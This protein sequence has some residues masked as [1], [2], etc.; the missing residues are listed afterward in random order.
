M[1]FLSLPVTLEYVE[2]VFAN[3]RRFI[4]GDNVDD[5][6]DL[7]VLFVDCIEVRIHAS[8]DKRQLAIVVL[9]H[10]STLYQDSLHRRSCRCSVEELVS[11][12]VD[13]L[14]NSAEKLCADKYTVRH[15]QGVAGAR[16]G[17]AVTAQA[18]V[19][20]IVDD[21]AASVSPERGDAS[22]RFAPP[23]VITPSISRLLSAAKVINRDIDE[24]QLGL[25]LVKQLV[26]SKGLDVIDKL[27]ENY[28]LEVQ[29][30]T[31][32]L[33]QEAVSRPGADPC[34]HVR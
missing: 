12:A 20:L 29:W 33:Q 17:L 4:R 8:K 10:R 16:F 25:F 24:P 14:K 31:E 26:R 30:L 1:V 21:E 22:L 32:L 6:E 18:L 28:G 13:E 23:S 7:C 2:I 3:A 15:L 34:R 19:N 5:M 9:M 27:Q 11:S